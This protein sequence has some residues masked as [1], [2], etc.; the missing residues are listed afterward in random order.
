MQKLFAIDTFEKDWNG[1]HGHQEE[2]SGLWV[3]EDVHCQEGFY[4]SQ[5]ISYK[6]EVEITQLNVSETF[7]Y[8]IFLEGLVNIEFEAE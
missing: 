2:Q 8:W 7:D 6:S 3:V 4:D 1:A 5:D